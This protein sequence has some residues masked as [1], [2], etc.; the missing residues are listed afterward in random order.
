MPGH[1]L[2]EGSRL[3][4]SDSAAGLGVL[5]PEAQQ[6][7]CRPQAS[8]ALP[9][10]QLHLQGR[11]AHDMTEPPTAGFKCEDLGARPRADQGPS[12]A[13]PRPVSDVV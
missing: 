3:R 1:V 13:L 7:G 5:L 12:P 9:I 4:A 8:S 11:Q 10:K 6:Q 2:Q